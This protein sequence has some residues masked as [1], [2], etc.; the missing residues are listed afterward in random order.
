M[1]RLLNNLILAMALFGTNASE[2]HLR[3]SNRDHLVIEGNVVGDRSTSM[4]FEKGMK[5]SGK[6]GRRRSDPDELA[7]GFRGGRCEG[8]MKAEFE[9]KATPADI[10]NEVAQVLT[11][12]M[13]EAMAM[14]N[15]SPNPDGSTMEDLLY[16]S[17]E[18]MATF[19]MELDDLEDG[20]KTMQ[21]GGMFQAKWGCNVTIATT[22][23]RGDGALSKTVSCG[24]A[25]GGGKGRRSVAP[26]FFEEVE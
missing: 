23:E 1:T 24:F 20:E 15:P 18:D 11:G 6:A 5:C 13:K 8:G 19:I 2:P 14:P 7:D 22:G 26:D 3:N 16:P 4:S 17:E 10:A 9:A 21:F 25:K 12:Q